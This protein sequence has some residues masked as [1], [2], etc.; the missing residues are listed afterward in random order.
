M[1]II[2]T[3]L[4]G[5]PA[6][7]GS[8][9]GCPVCFDVVV[10]R[11]R[12]LSIA[13]NCGAKRAV[14]DL[15]VFLD[16]DLV[17][18]GSFWREVLSLRR[19]EFKMTLLNRRASTRVLATF[20]A[21]F[22]RVGGFDEFF[23]FTAEDRDFLIRARKCGLKF[24]QM[25]DGVYRHIDHAPRY[26]NKRMAIRGIKENVWLFVKHGW[27]FANAELGLKT[28]LLAFQFR[29][30]PLMLLALGFYAWFSLLGGSGGK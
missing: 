15:L 19:G 7:C 8:L 29:T 23:T 30:L 6:T 28:R 14:G 18:K 20:K 24:I 13:R 25:P 16:D 22:W 12:G 26:G 1:S 2:V 10:A 4:K 5:N 11:E 3:T 21:D 27:R 17:L 9:K